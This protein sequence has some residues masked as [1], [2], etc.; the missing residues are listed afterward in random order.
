VCTGLTGVAITG[1]VQLQVGETGVFSASIEPAETS[2]PVSLLWSNGKTTPVITNTWDLPGLYTV[3]ITA[4]NCDGSAVVTDTLVVDV[5]EPCTALTG[6][7]IDGP[8]SLLV[9]ETGLYTVTLTPPDATLPFD[10]LWSNGITDTQSASY[11]WNEPGT[12]T[13]TLMASNCGGVVS[14]TLTVDVIQPVYPMWLPFIVRLD[15]P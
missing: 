3:V 5:Y 4:T 8:A 14:T 7:Q 11:S 2:A 9:G 13:V 10:I 15:A 6:A 1:T 12:Y